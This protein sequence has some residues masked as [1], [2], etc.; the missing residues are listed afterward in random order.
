[1]S[2]AEIIT[3]A[4]VQAA[5]AVARRDLDGMLVCTPRYEALAEAMLRAALATTLTSTAA[6]EVNDG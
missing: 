4:M 3:P 5:A 1:M 6:S 2:D